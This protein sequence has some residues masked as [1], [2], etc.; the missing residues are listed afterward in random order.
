M[1]PSLHVPGLDITLQSYIVL[2]S[3]AFG[4]AAVLGYRGAV[5]M[6]GIDPRNAR[7]ALLI[8]AAAALAGGYIHFVLA[9]LAALTTDPWRVLLSPS[10]HAPGA[11]IGVVLGLIAAARYVPMRRFADALAPGA[12]IGVAIARV[13]CFLNGCCF[14]D[15]CPYFWGV[16]FSRQHLSYLLQ[17]DKGVL[18]AGAPA[19]LPVHPLQLYFAFSAL[20]ISALLYWLRRR[21]RYHGRLALLFLVWFSATSALW[22]PLRAD[23]ADRVYI[24]PLPQ[25]LWVTILMASVSA[26]L[27]AVS[28]WRAYHRNRVMLTSF[29][30]QVGSNHSQE[31]SPGATMNAGRAVAETS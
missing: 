15:V 4:V 29:P 24:G 14:G 20:A 8:V 9:H 25:L 26:T 3:V 19:P 6:E 21:K 28:E 27:L 12:G 30:S 1:Y 2:L 23:T 31:A 11:V 17:V 5:A 22:E 13:G 18:P 16:R 10:L 7:R